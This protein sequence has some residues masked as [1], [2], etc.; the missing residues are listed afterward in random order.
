V[1]IYEDVV[2]E[3]DHTGVLQ[4]LVSSDD[5]FFE[6]Y[7]IEPIAFSI[8]D[9][10]EATSIENENEVLS[11]YPSVNNGVFTVATSSTDIADKLMIVNTI[12]QQVYTCAIQ[13]NQVQTI[14]VAHLP[15]GIYVVMIY[16]AETG[17]ISR[18]IEIV[19]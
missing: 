1:N 16:H 8:V 9:N 2:F 10:D 12:G 19:K 15:D 5:P 3:G 18:E 14:D 6:G 7:S 11:V 13:P 17:F 4:F